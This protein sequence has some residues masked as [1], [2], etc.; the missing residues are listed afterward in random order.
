MEWLKRVIKIYIENQL[1]MPLLSVICYFIKIKLLIKKPYNIRLSF[2][3]LLHVCLYHYFNISYIIFSFFFQLIFEYIYFN[4][5]ITHFVLLLKYL[6]SMY[7]NLYKILIFILHKFF[8]T[9]NQSYMNGK[10]INI[11]KETFIITSY[12]I[13]LC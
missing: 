6:R 5:T 8:I 13:V 11:I 10:D 1:F 12:N 9:G 7:S 3:C 2:Y 4:F